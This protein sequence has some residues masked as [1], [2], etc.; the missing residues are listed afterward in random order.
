MSPTSPTF[1][2]RRKHS[3]SPHSDK[4]DEPFMYHAPPFRPYPLENA[5]QPPSKR[6]GQYAMPLRN[7]NAVQAPA[8]LRPPHP[9]K[10][11]PLHR[12]DKPLS[13]TS[14]SITIGSSLTSTTTKIT[15]FVPLIE[16]Q[17][18]VSDEP[19][20]PVQTLTPPPRRPSFS[21][22]PWILPGRGRSHEMDAC[23]SQA[24]PS[25]LE[26]REHLLRRMDSRDASRLKTLR[27]CL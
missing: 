12:P 13:S 18:L 9:T 7:S 25:A 6:S 26:F 1:Q 16:H 10:H 5:T 15:G 3:V 23:Y 14:S 2:P 27:T 24:D 22:S 20:K 8:Q 21:S 17:H 19:R 11:S 4:D